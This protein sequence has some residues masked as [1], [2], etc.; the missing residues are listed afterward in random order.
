MVVTP[1]PAN[2]FG[3]FS[4]KALSDYEQTGHALGPGLGG[5]NRSAKL[6]AVDEQVHGDAL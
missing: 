3:G 4:F 6:M 5:L 2:Y 1:V